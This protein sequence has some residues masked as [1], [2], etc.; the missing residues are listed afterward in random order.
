MVL[1][2]NGEDKLD[3]SCEK[4]RI[5]TSSQG[6]KERPAGKR[7]NVG[8]NVTLRHVPATIVAALKQ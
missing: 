5:I 1:E 6:G 3:R 7:G 8:I 4:R 2:N